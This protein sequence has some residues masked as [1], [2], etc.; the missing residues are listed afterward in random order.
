MHPQ[1]AQ[2][3]G[4]ISIYRTQP[5]QRAGGRHLRCRDKFAQG[6]NRLRHTYATTNVQHRLF[7]LRQ[8]LT[9]LFNF[10]MRK[11]VV[12]SNGGE[13]RLQFAECNPD[14]FRDI[15]QNRAGRPELATSNA[16]A[17]T[18]GSSSRD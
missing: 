18:R 2:I 13:V 9:R 3:V 15:N 4:V 14:I 1:H 8:H 5:F 11:G 17:I 7:R 10:R 6:R 12:A 16:S